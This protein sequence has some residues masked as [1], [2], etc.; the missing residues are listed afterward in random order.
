MHLLFAAVLLG[1]WLLA[2]DFHVIPHSGTTVPSP[3]ALDT[4]WA[5]FDS[6]LAEM[7][8][9]DPNPRVVILTGDFLRHHFPRN[10]ALAE[11]TMTRIARDFNVTFPRAQF[12]IVPGNNDD[13]CGDYRATPGS[14][15]FAFLARVWAP[16]VNRDGAAPEFERNFARYG[17]YSARLPSSGLRVLA[18]DSVYWSVFYRACGNVHDA[19]RREMRWLER[20]LDAMPRNARAV[21][22]MHIPPGVDAHSTLQAHRLLV[23]PFWRSDSADAFVRALTP[24]ASRIAF[25]IGAH[26]HRDD[27]R[28]FGDVPLL[29]APSISPVYDNNPTFLRLDV[30]GDG[31]LRDYTP[32]VFDE[33]SQTWQAADSFDRV[34][35]VNAFSAQSLSAVHARLRDDA[36]LRARW[37]AMYMSGSDDRDIAWNTWRTYWCAQTQLVPSFGA[38][39]RLQRRLAILPVAAGVAAAAIVAALVLLA[40]RLRRSR[41]PR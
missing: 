41:S 7:R 34:Y 24:R 5:L 17:W 8:K 27:F 25:A 28:L 3:Y 18:L 40:M 10:V 11:Q 35:G 14:S 22:V 13:P 12:I 38:C 36:D 2:G 32:Y 29:V 19:P 21:V 33:P 6:T 9:A 30:A 26:V 23:V 20:S 1:H 37:S 31:S 39:A 15:Y 16:L 4:D